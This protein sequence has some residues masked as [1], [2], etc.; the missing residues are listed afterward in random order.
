MKVLPTCSLT[1]TDMLLGPMWGT[2]MH[3]CPQEGLQGRAC[4]RG[5]MAWC[6]MPPGQ[7]ALTAQSRPRADSAPLQGREGDFP[8][9][10]WKT[11]EP[12]FGK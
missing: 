2:G 10:P 7:T 4:F 6:S 1:A 9:R 11:K 5:W 3:V 12:L 8:V